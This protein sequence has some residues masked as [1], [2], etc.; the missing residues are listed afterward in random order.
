MDSW[1]LVDAPQLRAAQR[2]HWLARGATW[3]AAFRRAVSLGSAA[4]GKTLVFAASS[5]S[6]V[7]GVGFVWVFAAAGAAVAKPAGSALGND[8]KLQQVVI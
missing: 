4:V 7:F 1:R 6:I 8:D 2:G 5:S 3:S